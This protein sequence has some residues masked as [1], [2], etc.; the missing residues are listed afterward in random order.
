MKPLK[1][2]PLASLLVPLALGGCAQTPFA[3][4]TNIDTEDVEV[5]V[6]YSVNPFVKPAKS[7]DLSAKAYVEAERGCGRY[8]KR[9]AELSRRITQHGNEYNG[10]QSVQ[11]FLYTCN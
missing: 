11:V 10:W 7:E 9:P 3:A 5:S 8:D 1:L 4:I 2:L 6:S